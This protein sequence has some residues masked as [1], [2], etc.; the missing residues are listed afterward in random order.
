MATAKERIPRIISGLEKVYPEAH[1]ELAYSDPFQLLIATILSAQCSD[2]QVNLVT[3]GL[4]KKYQ[5]AADFADAP[6]AE[7]E[8]AIRSIGLYRSKAKNIQAACRALVE[9]YNGQVPRTMDELLELNGVGRKTANVVLGN[10]FNIS[11]GVVVDTHVARLSQRL[12]LTRHSAP[13]KIEVDLLKLVPADK[14]TLF[15]HLLIWHGRRRCYARNPDCPQ[16]EI[17][18]D[19]PTGQ[20]ILKKRLSE[21][22]K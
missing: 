12:A 8:N 18:A 22:A 13:A 10:A 9:K 1:C 20:K 3:P 17:Q 15:S 16:C 4:F 7:L 21:K 2:R 19:C 5:V 11:V 14:W 6:L